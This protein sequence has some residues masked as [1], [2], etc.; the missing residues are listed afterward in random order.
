MCGMPDENEIIIGHC[1]LISYS[2]L[3]VYGKCGCPTVPDVVCLNQDGQ[4][5]WKRR[6][7]DEIK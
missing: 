1:D 5:R 7:P 6:M 4:D 3:S 2:W